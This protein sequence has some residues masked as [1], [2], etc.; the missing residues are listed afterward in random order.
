MSL[1]LSESRLPD[2][3]DHSTLFSFTHSIGATPIS[4]SEPLPQLPGDDAPAFFIS[5]S[6][7]IWFV[8]T[9]PFSFVHRPIGTSRPTPEWDGLTG[10]VKRVEMR[11]KEADGT[12]RQR[13]SEA[14]L[15]TSNTNGLP[16][17]CVKRAD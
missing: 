1:S 7:A 14:I 12:L 5:P 2:D 8:P 17:R 3:S 16:R 9:P 13:L 15:F 6:P 10:W 11:A 4:P